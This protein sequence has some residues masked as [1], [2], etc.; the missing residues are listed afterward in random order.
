MIELKGRNIQ[1]TVQ[2]E[3]G[4]TIL[5]LAIH[6]K[7]DWGY[8]CTRGTCARCRC[9]VSEGMEFLSEP[10]DAEQDRLEPEEIEQGYRL[11]CQARIERDGVIKVAHRPYF[12]F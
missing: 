5:K 9:L 2:T 4:M 3:P 1:K 10:N 6:H 11:G 8:N 12:W 7:I